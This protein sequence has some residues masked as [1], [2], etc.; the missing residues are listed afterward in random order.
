MEDLIAYIV[1]MVSDRYGV[2]AVCLLNGNKI[3][4][5]DEDSNTGYQIEITVTT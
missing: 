5:S 1:E 4:V 3:C 2:D